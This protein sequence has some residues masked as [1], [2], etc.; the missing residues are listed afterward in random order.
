MAVKSLLARAKIAFQRAYEDHAETSGVFGAGLVGTAIFKLRMR[1]HRFVEH[2]AG[3][4]SAAAVTVAVVG[5]AAVP[6]S[7]VVPTNA[8]ELAPAVSVPA[9]ADENDG[10]SG[11]SVPTEASVSTSSSGAAA[12]ASGGAD[13]SS[14]AP[15]APAS[16]GVQVETKATLGRE[17]N[18]AGIGITTETDGPQN[19]RTTFAGIYV[20]DCSGGVL[21]TT[22]CTA[23]ET[24]N[25]ASGA[26]TA[27]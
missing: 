25:E 21:V 11:G 5:V 16:G 18:G 3:M 1:V 8:H 19:D 14:V 27:D 12:S 22:F 15:E 26:P 6:T 20:E 23:A 7:L 9:P 2:H 24:A 13:S 10:D 17:G 4:V